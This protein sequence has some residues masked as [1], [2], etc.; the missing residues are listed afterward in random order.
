MNVRSFGRV[1][2]SLAPRSLPSDRTLEKHASKP[3]VPSFPKD[4]MVV[5]DLMQS[6]LLRVDLKRMHEM[7]PMLYRCWEKI[8]SD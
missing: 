2:D 5:E 6:L 1:S 7:D 4:L 8:R 3:M